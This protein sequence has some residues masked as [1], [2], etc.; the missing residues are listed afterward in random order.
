[1][2]VPLGNSNKGNHPPCPL[3]IAAERVVFRAVTARAAAQNLDR[4]RLDTSV[5]QL[6]LVGLSQIDLA[7]FAET[8]LPGHFHSNFIAAHADP[9]PNRRSYIRGRRAELVPHSGEGIEHDPR[10][11][12]APACVDSRN[13]AVPRISQPSPVM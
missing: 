8:E 2:F 6:T 9:R 5:D 13:G 7:R 11:R 1:V 4:L 10:R 3:L 12:A